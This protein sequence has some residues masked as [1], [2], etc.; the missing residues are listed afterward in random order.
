MFQNAVASKVKQRKKPV[1]DWNTRDVLQW[2]KDIDFVK[3][4]EYALNVSL[5]GQKLLTFPEQQ[6]CSAF[7]LGNT[8]RFLYDTFF[9]LIFISY[10]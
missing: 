10:R 5:T 8:N 2:L 9:L 1:I 7:D 6:I 4:S 3:L